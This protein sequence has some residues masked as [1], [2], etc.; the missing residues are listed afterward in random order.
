MCDRPTSFSLSCVIITLVLLLILVKFEGPIVGGF[1][2]ETKGWRWILGVNAILSGVIWIAAMLTTN[3]TYTP[4]ILR[5][6]AKAL[7][8]MTRSVY[9]SR[10][11]VRKPSRTL[12][13]ELWVSFTRPWILLSREPIVLL[14]GLYISIIYATLYMFFAAIPIVFEETRGWG[15]GVA[16]LPFVGVA[17]GVCLAVLA[18]GVDNKKYMRLTVAAATAGQALEPEARLHNAMVGS[19][20]L[21]IGLFMFAWTTYPS[22]HWI[23]PVIGATLFSCGLVMVFISLISYLIDSCKFW[24]TFTVLPN[25][26][27][28]HLYVDTVYVASALA[29]NTVLR[30]FFATAFPLFTAQMYAGLGDQWASSIPAF[31]VVGCLPFPFLFYKYGPQIRSKCKYAAEAAE[32]LEMM[33]H[34]DVAVNG[35]KCVGSEERAE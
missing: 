14:T 24:S 8:R 7:S 25:N 1:I 22:V 4:V 29:A 5:F 2:G 3:E 13:Q 10:L 32:V 16:G 27:H 28:A 30:S 11:H 9:V 6:R 15:Q 31:L 20:V 23:A 19:I 26:R 34:R 21:P 33:R 12:S 17:I 35:G 18:A